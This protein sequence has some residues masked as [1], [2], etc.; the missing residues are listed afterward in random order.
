[1]I[2]VTT[3]SYMADLKL[4]SSTLSLSEITALVGHP[5]DPTSHD[6]GDPRPRGRVWGAS[7]WRLSSAAGDD[8]SLEQHLSELRS[9]AEKRGLLDKHDPPGDLRRVLSV[10]AKYDTFTCTVQLPAALLLPFLGAGFDLVI[11]AYPTD[12]GSSE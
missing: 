7:V 6:L 9:R 8:A 5:P 11:S 2:R 1:V 4:V 3:A 10:A 12:E